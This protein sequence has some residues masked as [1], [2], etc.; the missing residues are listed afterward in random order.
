MRIRKLL[1]NDAAVCYTGAELHMAK[2]CAGEEELTYG[3]H[4]SMQETGC[5]AGNT[6]VGIGRCLRSVRYRDT[7]A[8]ADGG[9]N[10]DSGPGAHP[11]ACPTYGCANG[12]RRGHARCYVASDNPGSSPERDRKARPRWT[13]SS[14]A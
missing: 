12:V 11:T 4:P 5:P 13:G 6:A 8:S 3:I 7:R 9:A 1:T 14:W 2:L 10:S